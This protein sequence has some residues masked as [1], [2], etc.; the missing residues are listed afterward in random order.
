LDT[1]ALEHISQ[2]ENNIYSKMDTTFKS[3]K[4]EI[5][6]KKDLTP[7]IEDQIKNIIKEALTEVK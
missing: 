7:E 2:F 4:D 5:I 6:S 1:L 3:L